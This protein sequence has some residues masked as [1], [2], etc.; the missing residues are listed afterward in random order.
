MTDLERA[1]L[2]LTAPRAAAAPETCGD[3]CCPPAN[4]PADQ[5]SVDRSPGWAQAARRARALSW[6]SLLWMSAEGVLGLVAGIQAQ[7]ISLLGWALGSVIEGLAS[8]IVI[9]RFTGARTQSETAEGRAQKAVAVSFFLLA[10]YIAVEAVRDLISGHQAAASGLGVII[11]V[12]SLLVMPL[13]GVAKQRLG[14]TLNSGATAGEGVQNLICAAQAAAVLIGIAATAALGWSWADPVIA[15]L[16]AGWAV[17]EGV[18]AWQGNDC[19]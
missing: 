15:L 4:Q 5:A 12:A 18:E 2:P 10:P 14:R 9:W 16:L 19:C 6:A 17:K 1:P 11:T 3:G 7:S 8:V 13:L